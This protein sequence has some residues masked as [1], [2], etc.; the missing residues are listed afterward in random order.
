LLAAITR[1]QNLVHGAQRRS[2]AQEAKA[3]EME[4]QLRAAMI[5]PDQPAQPTPPIPT[6]PAAKV[7]GWIRAVKCEFPAVMDI[8]LEADGKQVKLH[9][10]NHY[11]VKFAAVGKPGR[12][13]FQPCAELEGK[14]VFVEY[15]TVSGREFAGLIQS[16]LI[17]NEKE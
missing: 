5:I 4:A 12:N 16:I 15:L 2:E 3:R 9:V 10:E 13:D 17:E 8:V 14:L 1:R 6:G 7:R 11:E